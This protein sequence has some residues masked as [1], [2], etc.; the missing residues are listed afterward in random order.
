MRVRKILKA[1]TSVDK[2]SGLRREK[3]F[4]CMAVFFPFCWKQ[5]IAC[6]IFFSKI[7]RKSTLGMQQWWEFF[8]SFFLSFDI[9]TS[10]L[11][12]MFFQILKC[13]FFEIIF[14]ISLI[15][16]VQKRLIEKRF[17]QRCERYIF[18]SLFIVTIGVIWISF[19]LFQTWMTI[20][21]FVR[22]W[23]GKL[24]WSVPTFSDT[25]FNR[26]YN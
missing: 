18:K 4:W 10:F 13:N 16:F 25:K 19:I 5:Y 6:E 15:H 14:L 20:T 7:Y 2:N 24:L 8:G 22:T 3:R 9:Q 23:L 21:R 11:E 12:T 17:F 1:A 26:I